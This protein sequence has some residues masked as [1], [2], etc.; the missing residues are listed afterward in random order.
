MN[1]L[2]DLLMYCSYIEITDHSIDG[3]VYPDA[4]T[5]TITID[6]PLDSDI[7]RLYDLIEKNNLTHIEVVNVR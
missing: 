5:P 7:N 1:N 3:Y 6:N 2:N 4:N